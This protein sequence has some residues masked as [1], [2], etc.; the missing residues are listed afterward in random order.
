MYLEKYK[1]ALQWRWRLKAANH[2]IIASGE[3]YY[4]ESDCD[5]AINLVKGTTASTPV[6]LR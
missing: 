6:Y 4:N 2:E 1:S 3:S 5:R